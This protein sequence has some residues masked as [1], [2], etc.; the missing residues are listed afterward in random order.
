MTK[1]A[2]TSDHLQIAESPIA[3]VKVLLPL[4]GAQMSTRNRIFELCVDAG[5]QVLDAMMEQDREALC[6]P[7]WKR[8]PERDAGRAGK[9]PSTVTLGGRRI[10]VA[11]SRVRNHQG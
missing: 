8:D 6:G 5:R 2:K 3:L 9:P 7:L 1:H 11:R 10:A 4:L